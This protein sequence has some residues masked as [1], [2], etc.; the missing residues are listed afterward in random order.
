MY[1][2]VGEMKQYFTMTVTPLSSSSTQTYVGA[3]NLR[4]GD[5][6]WELPTTRYVE[7]MLNGH[8]MEDVMGKSQFL[9]PRT[10]DTAF[11]TNRLARS[12]A[13]PSKSDIVAS[14]RLLRYLRGTMDFGLKRQVQNQSLLNADGDLA[15]DRRTRKSMS[16]WPDGVGSI[17]DQGQSGCSTRAKVLGVDWRIHPVFPQRIP[18]SFV[19]TCLVADAHSRRQR[20][21]CSAFCIQTLCCHLAS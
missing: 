3:R 21:R 13:K 4:H 11:A 20:A 18:A 12:L 15:G 5:A 16:S 14:K 2:V 8:G 19:F 10:P 9:A 17:H 7:G 6:I 1:E